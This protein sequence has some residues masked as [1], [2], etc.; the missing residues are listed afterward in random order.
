M[1]N[2]V[3]LGML[4]LEK[5]LDST[6]HLR[7]CIF[8]IFH[9]LSSLKIVTICQSGHMMYIFYGSLGVLLWKCGTQLLKVTIFPNKWQWFTA[10]LQLQRSI[11][12]SG[13]LKYSE[14]H[15][16]QVA[17]TQS[18]SMSNKPTTTWPIATFFPKGGQVSEP[19][20]R[21]GEKEETPAVQD[22]EIQKSC[23]L[24]C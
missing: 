20:W 22:V 1:R 15:S 6:W 23:L 24:V 9:K 10:L 4:S 11:W 14:V 8:P 18:P 3:V 12:E 5:T 17:L 2:S 13:R 19:G 21:R 7:C 16:Y